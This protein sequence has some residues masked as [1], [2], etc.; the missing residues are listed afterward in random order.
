MI[1]DFIS[2]EK[3]LDFILEKK[4]KK[5]IFQLFDDLGKEKN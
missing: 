1:K 3:C 4:K 2:E 5:N